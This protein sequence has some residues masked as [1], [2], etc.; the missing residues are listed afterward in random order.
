MQVTYSLKLIQTLNHK[1]F[2]NVSNNTL[3]LQK[4]KDEIN[5][6]LKTKKALYENNVIE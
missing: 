6:I 3:L 4:I 1:C 2:S 5:C